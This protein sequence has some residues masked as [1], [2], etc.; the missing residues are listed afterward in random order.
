MTEIPRLSCD[1]VEWL[2]RTIEVPA[3]PASGGAFA[4]MTEATIR[5]LAFKAGMRAV[6]DS[7]L[8]EYERAEQEQVDADNEQ[9]HESGD[10]DPFGQILDPSGEP[11]QNV[12][13]LHL[14]D[15][16]T[17]AGPDSGSEA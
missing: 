12:A 6:V 5:R 16:L 1:L 10:T 17:A 15:S 3:L 4:D 14:A 7:L 8:A 2:D 13:S 11:H 9:L